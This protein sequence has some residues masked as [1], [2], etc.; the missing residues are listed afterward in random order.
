M[1][2]ALNLDSKWLQSAAIAAC[3]ALAMPATA[4]ETLTLIATDFPPYTASDLPEKGFF[5][6]L[7]QAAFKAVGYDTTVVVQPWARVMAQ[8]RKGQYDAVLAVWYQAEREQFLAFTD[9]LWTNHIGFFGRSDYRI[10]VRRLSALKPYTIGVVRDYANPPE[11]EAAHLNAEPA[12]DDLTNL[13]KL[14]AGHID[15]VL[16][17]RTLAE[18]LVRTRMAEA[19]EQIGWLEPPVASMPL[20]VGLARKRTN[21]QQHLDDFNRGLSIIRRNGEYDRIVKRLSGGE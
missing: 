8:M 2:I 7:A 14:Q 9:P 6:A 3:L 15:L 10:D 5:T 11:F 18:F 12:V 4:S 19:S 13:R 16:I 21:Y 1:R 20:Y 17:D